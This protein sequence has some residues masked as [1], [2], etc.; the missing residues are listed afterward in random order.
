LD[1][2]GA[3]G[4]GAWKLIESPIKFEHIAQ[5]N[6]RTIWAKTED[7]K[8]YYKDIYCPGRSDCDQWIEI[9]EES[10]DRGEEAGSLTI[11]KDTCIPNGIKYP[12]DPH[13]IVV[14]CALAEKSVSVDTRYIVY[15]ALLDDGA[16]WVWESSGPWYVT[17]DL[18]FIVFS[19][20]IGLILGVVMFR[21]FRKY[22]Q[23]KSV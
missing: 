12:R 13:G 11:N 17:F 19:P 9:K 15:Y 22:R 5:A 10:I 3:F 18:W 20:F 21:S 2:A 1:D 8:F 6:T 4:G 7:N 14:E 23:N 16:V